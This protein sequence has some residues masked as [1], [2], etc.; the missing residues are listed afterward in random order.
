MYY[1]AFEYVSGTHKGI[2]FWSSYASKE[3]FQQTKVNDHEIV[4]AEGYDEYEIR[5]AADFF[6]HKLILKAHAAE[7]ECAR[8]KVWNEFQK[9]G[10]RKAF[11]KAMQNLQLQAKLKELGDMFYLGMRIV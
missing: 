11:A 7:A 9:T 3:T 2:R 1:V 8:I 4:V 6:D 5:G 10:D